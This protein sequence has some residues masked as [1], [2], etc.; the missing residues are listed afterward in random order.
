M[1]DGI[2]KDITP[3]YRKKT[4]HIKRKFYPRKHPNLNHLLIMQKKT[5]KI[6]KNFQKKIYK[7][8]Y[9][10]LSYIL[11][12]YH[13]IINYHQM[14]YTNIFRY[15]FFKSFLKKFNEHLLFSDSNKKPN[16]QLFS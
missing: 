11:S 8:A 6:S 4:Q 13:I 7:T 14:T 15:F 12:V 9:L 10:N 1:N 5:N 16:Y 3:E 2:K